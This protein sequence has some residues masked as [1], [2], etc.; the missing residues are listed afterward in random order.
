[1]SRSESGKP[2]PELKW[3]EPYQMVWLVLAPK[4]QPERIDPSC[5]I[6]KPQWLNILHDTSV[7]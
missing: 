6:L 5:W 7:N 4:W 2:D 1:M 3:V